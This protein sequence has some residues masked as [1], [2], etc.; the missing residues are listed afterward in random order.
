MAFNNKFLGA[1]D[2]VFSSDF[3]SS[4][5]FIIFLGGGFSTL[6][7]FI[8]SQDIVQRFTTTTDMGQLTKMLLGNGVLSL[9]SATIFYLVGTALYAFYLQNPELV[10]T[11]RPDQVFISY[12][13]YELPVGV[14][15]LLIA[16]VYAAAQSTISSGINAVAASW[17]LDIRPLLNPEGAHQ[18]RMRTGQ[19]VSLL[20]GILSIAIAILLS[21]GS[22]QSAYSWFN[23]FMGLVLGALVGLFVM[24]AFTETVSKQGAVAGFVISAGAIVFLKY[25]VPS[26]SFWWYT[27]LTILVSLFVGLL[28][29]RIEAMR[30]GLSYRAQPG[31][32]IYSASRE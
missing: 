18:N 4:S 21:S 29:S 31:T 14:S 13:T 22:M 9:F 12:I 11:T 25:F 1:K 7:S 6:A 20:V 23:G 26:V 5:L 30:S 28:V 2:V 16:G 32:T 27:I 24:G 10:T 17:V 8:S 15:G 3:L 19:Y